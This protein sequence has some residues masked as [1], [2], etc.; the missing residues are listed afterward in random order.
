MRK[1]A[2]FFTYRSVELQW[3][4]EQPLKELLHHIYQTR[5]FRHIAG[6]LMIYN[7]VPQH[8]IQCYLGH[9]SPDITAVYMQ[10]HNQTMKEEVA[11]FR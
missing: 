4:P 10:M 6:T 2:T 9:K 11:K 5:E 7:G 8:I 3:S 1:A